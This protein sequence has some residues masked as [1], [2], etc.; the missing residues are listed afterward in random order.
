LHGVF[1]APSVRKVTEL[2]YFND[3][4]ETMD[5]T[6]SDGAV[7]FGSMLANL[8]LPLTASGKSEHGYFRPL[9]TQYSELLSQLSEPLIATTDEHCQKVAATYQQCISLFAG[10]KSQVTK[11]RSLTQDTTTSL[12]TDEVLKLMKYMN[13]TI[14]LFPV[15]TGTHSSPFQA[16]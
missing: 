3:A 7:S 4:N 8:L 10:A 2:V 6:M 16:Q 1:S 9:M 12:N 15:V 11:G 14:F 5:A 13:S